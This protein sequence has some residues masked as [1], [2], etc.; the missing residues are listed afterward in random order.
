MD[1]EY[2]ST[3]LLLDTTLRK[4]NIPGHFDSEGLQ[5]K[6][7]KYRKGELLIAPFK[8]IDALLFLIKGK[9][10]IYGLREDGSNFSVFLAGQSIL[11]GDMEFIRKEPLPFYT[12]ALEDVLCVALPIEQHKDILE[13]DLR[14]LNFLLHSVADKFHMFFQTSTTSQPVEDKLISFLRD[15]QS[16]HTLHG[17]N[18]GVMQLQCSRSQLQRVVRK[19]QDEGV[20]QKVGKGQ[21]QLVMD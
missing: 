4:W 21:Y 17:M 10:S 5:F 11:L 13:N 19:L 18:V 9:V 14:F 15:I 6:L 3:Q 2:S 1:M 12:E 16:D 8:P 20:L 7:V